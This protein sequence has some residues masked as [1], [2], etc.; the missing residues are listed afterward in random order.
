VGSQG[1][2][3]DAFK[4][5]TIKSQISFSRMFSRITI[6]VDDEDHVTAELP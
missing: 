4:G 1:L 2:E 6:S 3:N 5:Q